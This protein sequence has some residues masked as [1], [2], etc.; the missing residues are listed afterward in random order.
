MVLSTL[1]AALVRTDEDADRQHRAAALDQDPRAQRTG[2]SGG[3]P[4][5][6]R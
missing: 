6:T 5:I 1:V 2:V 3:T 4:E